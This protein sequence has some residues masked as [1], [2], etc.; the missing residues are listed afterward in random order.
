MNAEQNVVKAQ[1]GWSFLAKWVAGT[2]LTAAV[3]VALGFSVMWSVGEP[4]VERFG[5]RMAFIA[6]V[7]LLGVLAGLGVAG[8]QAFALSDQGMK[9][10]R[11]LS[12]SAIGGQS[13]ASIAGLLGSG[14]SESGAS[15]TQVALILGSL[16]GL[17]IGLGQWFALR[18]SSM[19]DRGANSMAWIAIT[20]VSL[21]AALLI[22]F[23]LGGE[24]RELLA[25]T[26]FGLVF[27]CLTGLGAAWLFGS[28]RPA[29]AVQIGI[30]LVAGLLL[31]GCGGGSEPS[32]RFTEPR[33]GASVA[34]PVR[35][36]MAAENF[37]VEPAGDGAVHD[38]AGHLHIMVNTPCIAAGQTIP[39]DETHLHFGDGSTETEL[40]LE[41][42]T[43]TLCLQSA[44][45]AHTALPGE[46]MT[47]TISVTVP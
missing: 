40:A 2:T 13:G 18:R 42:G 33:D 17:G 19:A 3:G 34:A 4:L 41:S 39:K 44:D 21:V 37:T 11:W 46:G 28:T 1:A 9:P 38:G 24:G 36:V 43:H 30:L 45:G 32:V 10:A 22:A 35:I 15:D 16:L 20:A 26:G 5:E 7:G 31:A 25:F 12:Y 27:A 47:H 6:A 14:M 23:N 29:I 8:G